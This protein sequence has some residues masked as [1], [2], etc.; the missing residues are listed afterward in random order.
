MTESA[1][2]NLSEH[3]EPWA[4]VREWAANEYFWQRAT[5]GIEQFRNRRVVAFAINDAIVALFAGAKTLPDVVR[6]L[7]FAVEF[8]HPDDVSW[9]GTHEAFVADIERRIALLKQW[10]T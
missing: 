7:G 9:D 8:G 1:M 6:Q 3:L 2:P 4:K 10:A 5:T